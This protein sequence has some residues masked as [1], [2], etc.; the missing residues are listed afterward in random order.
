MIPKKLVLIRLIFIV[1]GY[2]LNTQNFSTRLFEF[3]FFEISKLFKIDLIN[4]SGLNDT[5]NSNLY[6]KITD[7]KKKNI[8]FIDN[9]EISKNIN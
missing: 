8:F 7:Y 2:S 6:E 9:L 3:I 1:D 5:E 4:I